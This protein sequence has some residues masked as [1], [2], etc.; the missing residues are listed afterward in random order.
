MLCGWAA[1]LTGLAVQRKDAGLLTRLH[2]TAG[3]LQRLMLRSQAGGAHKRQ[4]RTQAHHSVDLSG[5]A[6]TRSPRPACRKVVVQYREDCRQLDSDPRL[7]SSSGAREQQEAM[8]VGRQGGGWGSAAG[9][10]EVLQPLV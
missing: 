4:G 1:G 6:C 8:Q 5:P 3:W 10:A 2:G 9:A 7:A